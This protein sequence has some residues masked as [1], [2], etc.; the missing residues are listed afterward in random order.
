MTKYEA[1]VI[2]A[3]MG[4][5]I[6]CKMDEVKK[7]IETEMGRPVPPT[8][9]LTSTF[10]GEVKS[11]FRPKLMEIIRGLQENVPLNYAELIRMNAQP[12]YCVNTKSNRGV[13][14]IV[15]VLKFGDTYDLSIKGIAM[16]YNDKNLYTA[17]IPYRS[18]P[19]Y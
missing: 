8:E 4:S 10:W 7:F 13:W 5:P 11:F 9:F 17:W 14:G 3:Y 19:M 18:K 1:L 2:S 6:L 15:E 16:D 12:I